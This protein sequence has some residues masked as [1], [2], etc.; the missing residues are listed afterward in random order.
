MSSTTYTA[1]AR[2][3]TLLPMMIIGVLFFVMGFFTWLNGP[4]ISFVKV[5]FTLDDVNAF[6]VP[7]A[8]YLLITLFAFAA[9]RARIVA[10]ADAPVGSH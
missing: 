3:S 2:T 8:C 10:E 6:L 7:M 4:L 5:A 9:G 1:D